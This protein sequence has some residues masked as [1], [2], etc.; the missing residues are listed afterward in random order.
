MCWELIYGRI[1]ETITPVAESPV[2]T[3]RRQTA[4]GNIITFCQTLRPLPPQRVKR[5][6]GGPLWALH[7]NP[8]RATVVQVGAYDKHVENVDPAVCVEV[9]LPVA[10]DGGVFIQV[11]ADD[12]QV[13]DVDDA[14]EIRIARQ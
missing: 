12:D 1:L 5:C 2:V 11:V 13:N 6:I 7:T 9:Q 10:A 4:T 14:I 3:S 8:L